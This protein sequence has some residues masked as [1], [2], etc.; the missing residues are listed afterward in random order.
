MISGTELYLRLPSANYQGRTFTVYMEAM[1]APSETNARS[2]GNDYSVVI[3]PAPG[4]GLK[5]ELVRHA[6]LH[7]LLDPMVGRFAVNLKPLDPLMDSL[8]LAPMDESFPY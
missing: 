5:M 2:Y 1:G 7:F 6:F 8:R 3:T 4:S